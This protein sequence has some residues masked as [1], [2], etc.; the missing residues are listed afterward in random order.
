MKQSRF[1]R[2]AEIAGVDDWYDKWGTAMNLFFDIAEVLDMTDIEGDVT[3]GPF[4]QWGYRRSPVVAVPS[5]ETVAAR[6][7]DFAEG[8]WA[9]D[10]SYTVV[11]LAVAYR[12]EVITQA[13]LVYAGNVLERYTTLL[14]SAGVSY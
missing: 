7:E 3:P 12:D 13:D 1:A 10:C 8:E 4:A 2:I 9:D 11:A 6:A 14:Q 5:I